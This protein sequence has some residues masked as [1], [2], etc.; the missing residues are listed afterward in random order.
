MEIIRH[1][2]HAPCLRRLTLSGAVMSSSELVAQGIFDAAVP[3]AEVLPAAI[4]AATEMSGQAAWRAVKQQLRGG[5]R[6][7]VLQ[8]AMDGQEPHFDGR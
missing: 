8:R 4:A 5:L 1:E 6:E 2:I 7:S 3:L